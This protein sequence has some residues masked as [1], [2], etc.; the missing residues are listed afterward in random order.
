MIHQS[1][2]IILRTIDFQETSRIVAAYTREFGKVSLM[3]K[4]AKSSKSKYMGKLDPGM[5]VDLVYHNKAG[6]SIQTL[7]EISLLQ[8]F[9]TQSYHPD[10]LTARLA[11]TD[12]LNRII[13]E[14]MQHSDLYDKCEQ[15]I[16]WLNET[17]QEVITMFPYVMIRLAQWLGFGIRLDDQIHPSHTII[18]LDPD[19]GSLTDQP[20]HRGLQ[21]SLPMFSYIKHTIE[22]NRKAI[23]DTQLSMY[24]LRQLTYVMD[25]Y[26]S[27]HIDG[28][29]PR[30]VNILFESFEDLSV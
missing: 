17:H 11:F 26:L 10:R 27:F 7:S 15:V 2:A 20:G 5:L 21:L 28:L 3:A 16:L 1:R 30:S 22:S 9:S 18:F 14:G 13:E 29:K 8:A 24:E 19:T 25:R 6:R 23:L 4:G 12:L